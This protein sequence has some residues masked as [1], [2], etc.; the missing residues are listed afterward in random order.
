M[1]Q[2]V[3]ASE[4]NDSFSLGSKPR[5]R[6]ALKALQEIRTLAENDP[7]RADRA[8]AMLESLAEVLAEQHPPAAV[9]AAEQAGWEALG[10]QFGDAHATMR[11]EFRSRM[12]AAV[13][14]NESI[15]GD[16]AAAHHLGVD[17][18]RVPQ[19]LRERSLYAF[20]A[21]DTRYFPRWQFE[22]TRTIPGLR[23]VLRALDAR[24]HPL[25]VRHWFTTPNTDLEIGSAAISPRQWLVTGGSVDV[26][27]RLAEQ[28]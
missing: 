27:V 28:V 3:S 22:G 20:S 12:S 26:V 23:D 7:V 17:R 4:F 18:T 2:P 9:P 24:L 5:T 16:A 10:A 8:T 19:R 1:A 11:T 15:E 6:R 13:V 25:T 14:T 21:D